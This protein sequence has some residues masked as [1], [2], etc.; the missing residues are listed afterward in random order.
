MIEAATRLFGAVGFAGTTM[1]AVS[2]ES[3][4]SV[5]SVYF[6]FHN[7]AGLLEA[8][9]DL[10]SGDDGAGLA[11][12]PADPDA[13]LA[14]LVEQACDRLLTTGPLLIAATA[15]AAGD[16]AVA[17]ILE[18][19][20]DR[21]ARACIN[22]VQRVRAVRPLRAG[23]LSRPAAD[24]VFALVSPQVHDLLTGPRGWSHRRYVAWATAAVARELWGAAATTRTQAGR[25]ATASTSTSW[26]G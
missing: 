26:P 6:A 11:D 21:R 20:E 13:L 17:G 15:A 10:A 19:Q 12:P 22:L 9:F 5:Q 1:Q 2:S 16:E 14:Q 3:G 7:K 18:E 24:V 23:L 25:T 4:M 8:A